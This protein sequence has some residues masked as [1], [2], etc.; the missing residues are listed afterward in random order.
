MKNI[1]F[2]TVLF[3]SYITSCLVVTDASAGE[4]CIRVYDF[5][6]NKVFEWCTTFEDW[7]DESWDFSCLTP[8]CE[9]YLGPSPSEDEGADG[10]DADYEY[11]PGICNLCHA[12]RTTKALLK[13]S[14]ENT[15][16]N[17]QK[18]YFPKHI[19][20]LKKEDKK[21]VGYG[22]F[23][24]KESGKFTLY[25]KQGKRV[26]TFPDSS[27]VLTDFVG[28]PTIVFLQIERKPVKKRK[29]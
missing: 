6:L 26:K 27:I 16:K 3:L 22:L 17:H 14:E 25:D 5:E 29:E 23:L 12:G 11:D 13:Q 8:A 4:Q 20:K 28:K 10:E 19:L 21:H 7:P 15:S 9:D 18:V 1:F 24:V 2:A